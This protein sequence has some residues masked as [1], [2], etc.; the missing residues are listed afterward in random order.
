MTLTFSGSLYAN[1]SDLQKKQQDIKNSTKQVQQQLNETKQEKSAVALEIEAIDEQMQL[2]V[3]ELERVTAELEQTEVLLDK[4]STELNEAETLRAEQFE[5]GKDRLRVMYE[6]SDGGYLSYVMKASSISNL[7]NRIEYV[8]RVATY[9]KELIARMRETE[10]LIALKYDETEQYKGELE[11][12]VSEQDAKKH[13]LETVI[14]EK[15]KRMYSLDADEQSY[16]QKIRDMEQ[17]DKNLQS[18]IQKAQAAAEAARRAAEM[19]GKPV[20]VYKGGKLE[21]PTPASYRVTSNYGWRT[22]PRKQFHH[23]VD[24]GIPTGN[25]V[26]AAEAGVVVISERRGGY[27]LTIVVDHGGGMQTLYGHNS[28]L[29]AQVGQI[30]RRGEVVAKSG[31]TGDSTGPHLHFE[32]RVNGAS[33]SPNGYLGL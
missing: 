6:Y 24:I 23:G 26:V 12:L 21:W 28:K 1:I 22:S 2:V 13:S 17:E 20:P 9:D 32:V 27:G 3:A 31:N 18:A 4:T 8:N 25:D 16:L 11:V 29:V 5:L 7:I 33:T 15:T 10:A 19:A 30:V 14:S